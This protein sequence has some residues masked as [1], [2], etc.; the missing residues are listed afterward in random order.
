[1]K[2][3]LISLVVFALCALVFSDDAPDP[4][5]PCSF[6]MTCHVSVTSKDGEEL[7][8]SINE[9]IRDNG[10]YW[11]WK[12]MFKGNE[13]I[14]AIVPDHEWSLIWRPDLSTS[15]RHDINTQKCYQ[16]PTQL[17]PY[18]WVES[19]TYGIVWFDEPVIYDGKEA[20]CFT[21]VTLVLIK[22]MTLKLLLTSTLLMK[23]RISFISTVLLLPPIKR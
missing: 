16:D 14:S 13:F 12:S 4:L 8:S 15:F 6:R 21:G 22:S 7:A 9:L 18:K 3:T 19:K 2:A 5:F 1:M 23:I 10:D 11:V 20:T 17:T